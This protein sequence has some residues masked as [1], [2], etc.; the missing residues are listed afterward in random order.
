MARVLQI[1]KFYPPHMGGI[2]THLEN[3]CLEVRERF[4]VQVVACNHHPGTDVGERHG[5]PV[6]RLATPFAIANAPVS[7]GLAAA[8]R[9]ARPDLV[10]LHLP[11]PGGVLGLAASRYRGPV[12]VTY[13]S[14]IVRQR[15]WSAIFQPI[16]D[17]LLRR[18]KAIVVASPNYLES[19]P[20]LGRHRERCRVV[21][22][23]VRLESFDTVAPAA[24]A[25]LR[26]HYG[27]RLVLAVGRLVYYKGFEFLIRAMQRVRGR[28]LLIGGGPL[29]G[30][31]ETQAAEA[32][33]ADRV[34]FI[35]EV[36]D[37]APFYHAAEVF[38][39]PSIA[40]SE[41]FGIVQLEAMACGTPVVNT[42]L[43]SGVPWVSPHMLTG[44]T[45]P[46]AD[47]GALADA[48]T[49]LLDDADLRARL[50]TAGRARVNAEFRVETMGDRIMRIYEDALR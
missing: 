44:L 17:P 35:G 6:H 9:G 22:L 49:K 26:E 42:S 16:L 19:S 14:D 46:P 12:V 20:V 7:P 30:A 23:G 32:G 33:V 40:R 37:P 38:V 34:T 25:R 1:G 50:G 39:L 29:R 18:A 48:I 5:I 31:L 15:I 21:P 45:V 43:P 47:A 11:H 8:I 41:A 10:H 3:L 28:L 27:P 4:D 13:H 36:A 24:V 2:E